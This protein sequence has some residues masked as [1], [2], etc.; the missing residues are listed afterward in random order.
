[1]DIMLQITDPQTSFN[2]ISPRKPENRDLTGLGIGITKE[3][4]PVLTSTMM[5]RTY[6]MQQAVI[7][8]YALLC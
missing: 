3:D 8:Q 7:I 5:V 1:M 4:V 2:V 6:S